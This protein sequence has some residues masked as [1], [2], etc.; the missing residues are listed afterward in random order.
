ME[1]LF[2]DFSSNIPE[3]GVDAREGAGHDGATTP[4]AVTVHALPAVLGFEGI[5]SDDK[6]FEIPDG[7]HDAVAVGG[8]GA[9]APAI[10]F[11]V[12]GFD[13]YIGPVGDGTPAGEGFKGGDFKVA[14]ELFGDDGLFCFVYHW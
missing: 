9:F 5:V 14:H 12:I 8:K 11:G 4:E 10:Y 7:T 3:G 2:P 13:F 6:F 1:W